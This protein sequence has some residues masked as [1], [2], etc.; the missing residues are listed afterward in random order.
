MTSIEKRSDRWILDNCYNNYE[1]HWSYSEAIVGHI[2]DQ[3]L[4]HYGQTDERYVCFS[5]ES[6]APTVGLVELVVA[7]VAMVPETEHRTGRAY[8]LGSHGGYSRGRVAMS[9][10]RVTDN[11]TDRC[12][13]EWAIAWN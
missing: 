13:R 10:V 1:S 4:S 5:P 12:L 3:V 11:G 8:V 6:I 2:E 7:L 9:Q